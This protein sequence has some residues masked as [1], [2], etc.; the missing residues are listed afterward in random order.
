MKFSRFVRVISDFSSL[1]SPIHAT[2]DSVSVNENVTSHRESEISEIF[3]RAEPAVS[4]R[5]RTGKFQQKI[6]P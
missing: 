3:V 2:Q 4:R 1:V 5:R 6:P